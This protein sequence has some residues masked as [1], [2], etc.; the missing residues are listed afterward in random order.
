MSVRINN[1]NAYALN[2]PLVGL[3][4]QPIISQRAPTVN[5]KAEI[6]TLWID[7]PANDAY[8][9]MAIIGAAASWQTITGGF[10]AFNDVDI[11]PGD[12]T[13]DIGNINVTLGNIEA[14]A[15]SLTAGADITSTGGNI[16]C[17]AGNI[18]A[19]AGD[20]VA[21]AG[22]IEATAG[23]VTGGTGLIA[24]AGG[25]TAT[26][27]GVTATAGDITATADDIVATAGDIYATAGNIYTTAGDIYATAGNITATAGDITATAG[28][29]IGAQVNATGDLGGTLAETAMTNV[30]DA[31]VSTGVMTINSTTANPGANAGYLKFYL[32]ATPVWVPYFTVIAP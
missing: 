12:L 5:D 21:T 3:P 20:I 23:T 13:V 16:V 14:T 30:N 28:G 24:T 19:T 26:A 6:G 2:Q 7:Q 10:A 11:N 32:G 8:V 4:P 27:G 1:N 18:T 31:T 15:G 25:V 9:L 22:N 29:I 17:D